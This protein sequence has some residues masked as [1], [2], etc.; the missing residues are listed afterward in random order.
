M[1]KRILHTWIRR[2]QKYGR[3][4]LGSIGMAGIFLLFLFYGR[5]KADQTEVFRYTE[6]QES[7]KSFIKYAEFNVNYAALCKAYEYDVASYGEKIHLD[8]ITLLSYA[9]A[10]TGGEF[11]DRALSLMEDAA[12]QLQSG[13]TKE[14][15]IGD[16]KYYPYY[17]EVYAAVLGGMLGEFTWQRADG[18]VEKKYG[19]TAFSPIAKG[20][21]YSSYDDFGSSRS[22]GYSRP[23]LGHDMMGLVGTPIIAVEGGRVEALGWN[24]YGGWR[25]GIRSHDEKRY[26]YYAHLRQ[27]RPYAQDLKEG[28]TVEAGEVI[29]YMGHTGYSSTE[30][31]NNIKVV[32]LHFGMELVFDESQKESD[33]EIWID[34]YALTEF[35]KKNR[36]EVVRDDKTREWHKR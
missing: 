28:D 32:H 24:Q 15:L 19:L 31:T 9:A 26:Y 18:G 8:W 23:H 3:I 34:C 27:N 4:L 13:V 10:H 30:N 12:K 17:E 36:S 29:G 21:D 5:P 22:Y 6:Q 16:L 1:K 35:L 14:K 7:E 2:N 20:F 11:G 33:N 25:I